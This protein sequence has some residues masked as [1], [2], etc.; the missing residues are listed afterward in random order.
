LS[1]NRQVVLNVSF[2]KKKAVTTTSASTSVASAFADQDDSVTTS[3][4]K[5]RPVTKPIEY[6]DVEEIDE[7]IEELKPKTSAAAKK[8]LITKPSTTPLAK[9]K[10][11]VKSRKNSENEESDQVNSISNAESHE[12]GD[13]LNTDSTAR[14]KIYFYRIHIQFGFES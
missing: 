11:V 7:S 5:K 1:P 10:R 9:P 12:N 14:S 3:T 8:L 2:L 6:D 13:V 4:R